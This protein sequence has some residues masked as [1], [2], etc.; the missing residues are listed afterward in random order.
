MKKG[1]EPTEKQ[2]KEKVRQF[3]DRV[4]FSKYNLSTLDNL[5]D[6]PKCGQARAIEGRTCLWR[7]CR[8]SIPGHIFVP[9]DR[10]LRDY[11]DQV[12]KDCGLKKVY[13]NL[14]KKIIEFHILNQ[15]ILRTE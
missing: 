4:L 10:W 8:F 9:S 13:P 3:I 12:L 15:S 6:C 14:K 1:K 5:I 7:A 11:R 2:I